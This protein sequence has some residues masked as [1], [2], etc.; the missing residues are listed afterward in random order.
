M[1]RP[2][3]GA[4]AMDGQHRKECIAGQMETD[5]VKKRSI[6]TGRSAH[7]VASFNGVPAGFRRGSGGVEAG[8]GLFQS[9]FLQGFR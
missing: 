7:Y 6:C 4:C 8:S 1:S 3:V 2:D 9:H 5:R